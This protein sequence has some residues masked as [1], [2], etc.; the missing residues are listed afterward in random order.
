VLPYIGV[1][2]HGLNSVTFYS[3][4]LFYFL[5]VCVMLRS[6]RVVVDRQAGRFEE[7]EKKR[8]L[9]K[10]LCTRKNPNTNNRTLIASSITITQQLRL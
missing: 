5:F 10:F 4:L 1:H 8:M 9:C 7:E 6:V 2:Y 3:H